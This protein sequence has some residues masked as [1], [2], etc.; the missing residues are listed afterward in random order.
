MAFRAAAVSSLSASQ[1]AFSSWIEE[2][3]P[4]TMQVGIRSLGGNLVLVSDTGCRVREDTHTGTPESVP[5]AILTHSKVA[6]C[7]RHRI[8]V[9]AAGSG[10]LGTS[11]EKELADYLGQL[12]SVPDDALGGLLVE[13]GKKYFEEHSAGRRWEVLM[14]SLLV[15]NPRAEYTPFWKL[16]VGQQCSSDLSERCMVNGHEDNAAIFWLE[17]FKSHAQTRDVSATTNVAALTITMAGDLNPYGVNGLEVWQFDEEW[18]CLPLREVEAIV[19]RLQ[20]FKDIVANSIL[21]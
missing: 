4:M 19:V 7:K 12:E 14:H 11:P 13:W 3:T 21:K 16:R 8:A 5:S 1:V 17:Y 20:E 2:K 9:A 15:V 10:G 6:I 18:K